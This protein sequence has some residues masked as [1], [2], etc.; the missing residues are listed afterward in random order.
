MDRAG[1]PDP[2]RVLVVL[3]DEDVRVVLTLLVRS[4][5]HDCR[6]AG[7]CLTALTLAADYQP[8]VVLLDVCLPGPDGWAVARRLRGDSATRRA[9]IV[10]V[11]GLAGKHDHRDS[12][13]AGCDDHWEMPFGGNRLGTLLRSLRPSGPYAIL[14][15][16]LEAQERGRAPGPAALLAR[17]PEFAN[18]LKEFLEVFDWLEHVMARLRPARRGT[19]PPAGDGGRPSVG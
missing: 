8:D 7:D 12:A 14:A 15:E 5:G 3:D 13:Q 18:E 17:Y 19:E 1:P 11:S 10:S 4:F 6:A 9:Y 2:L 16:Y